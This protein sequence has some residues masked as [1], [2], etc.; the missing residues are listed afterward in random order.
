MQIELA[1]KIPEILSIINQ[2]INNQSPVVADKVMNGFLEI[3]RTLALNDNIDVSRAMTDN[4][5]KLTVHLKKPKIDNEIVGIVLSM[6]LDRSREDITLQGLSLLKNIAKT[7]T[8]DLVE[9]YFI[10]EVL[11]ISIDGTFVVNK[12][13]V[14]L[15]SEVFEAPKGESLKIKLLE[16][17]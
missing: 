16:L 2:V 9:R 8:L 1:N 15:V 13:I 6:I 10:R 3:V 7:I 14:D 4:I 11:E 12:Q 17:F 5:P